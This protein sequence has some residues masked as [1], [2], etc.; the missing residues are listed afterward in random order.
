L[1][2]WFTSDLHLGHTNIIGYENR[3]FLSV[4]GM[5]EGIID[6][7]NDQVEPDDTV[8]VLGDFA[9]GHVSDTLLLTPRLNG[10]KLLL[11]GN[12]DR[13]WVGHPPQRR[14]GWRKRYIGAGFREVFAHGGPLRMTWETRWVVASHFPYV[15]IARHEDRFNDWYPQDEGHFLIHG[16]VHSAWRQ[17]GREINVGLDPWGGRLV[18]EDELVELVTSEPQD[19]E[20][21][22]WA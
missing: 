11:C 12:H 8:W 1:S 5:N 19:L 20:V 3:P 21:I 16:H 14:E 22:P 6:R 7:W 10:Q 9:M 2:T 15:G 17:R 13:P 18:H 4:E